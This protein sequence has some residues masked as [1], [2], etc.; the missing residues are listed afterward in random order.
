MKKSDQLKQT[1][2]GKVEAQSA[3]ITAAET[4]N[5]DFTPDEQSQFDALDN[6]IRTL[7]TSIASQMRI[8][9]AQTRAIQL[10]NRDLLNP[11]SEAEKP[12]Q[13]R[14]FSIHRAVLA[15]LGEVQLDPEEMRE[16][17]EN[18][19]AAIAS[20]ITPDGF[21]FRLPSRNVVNRAT[22]TVTGDS[23]GYGGENVATDVLAPID[24]LRPEPLLSRSGAT[25]LRNC[26]G[27]L[28][29]PKNNGGIVATWEGETDETASTAN[30]YGSLGLTP[31]R[32]S[33][34]VP[35][36]IQML[37]QS[38]FDIELYT[39][40]QINS[41]LEN[42]IDSTGVNGPGTGGSPTGILNTSGVSSVATG[43][44]GSAP[45]WDMVVDSETA[46]FVENA[47]SAKLVYLINPKTRGKFKKTKH[48]AG[49][50]NYLMTPQNEING[51]PVLTSNH[52][53]SDLTKGSGTALSALIF[54]DMSQVLIAQWGMM[55]FTVDPYSRKKEGLVEIT[56]NLYMDIA[57]KQPKAFTKIVG[58]I[59]T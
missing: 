23:G 32:L 54:G 24:F 55:D 25:Y 56:V 59:T 57:V 29:F 48:E 41:A 12:K 7:D 3:L 38:S 42:K 16:A 17:E 21:V 36:S 28:K 4:A 31:K 11:N 37:R 6:E 14:T 30:A 10:E 1:R 49:D 19:N 5:R 26:V 18:R 52:V 45:T 44:N 40:N 51:Y 2:A 9:E 8:E 47:N 13:K 58:L 27:D 35:V 15:E 39:V 50:F 22:Q 46:V 34:T 53:P 20:G 43:T 33:V